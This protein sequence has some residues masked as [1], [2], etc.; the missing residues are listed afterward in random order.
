MFGYL[1]HFAALGTSVAWSFSSVFFTLSGRRV[2]SAVVNRTR[3]VL[4]V[5]LV[6]ITHRVI[7]GQFLPVGAES[8]R[9]GWLGLSGLLGYVIGDGFLFQA[10]VMIGPRLS[11]LLM[12][13]N[14]VL[15]T[16]L[17]WVLLRE[18]LSAVEICGI[19]LSVGG[20]A[21][22]IADRQPGATRQDTSSTTAAA[23]V[24]SPGTPRNTRVYT[25][26][27]LFGLGAAFGQASGLLASK[28][29]LAGDFPALSGNLIRLLVAMAAIWIIAVCRGKVRENFQLLRAAPRAV[30]GIIGGAVAGPFLGVWLSLVAVQYAPLGIASTLMSFPPIFLLPVGRLMFGERFGARAVAGTVIAIAGTAVLFLGAPGAAP[31]R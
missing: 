21:L 19:M 1:G 14:P 17:A 4:A 5:I 6:A 8:F 25:L 15:S 9:W 13:M 12:A 22:V 7:V 29:G 2:G 10:F 30:R 11:M 28:L 3:L 31:A 18:T 24:E 23:P 27:V 16:I 20:V 26:G